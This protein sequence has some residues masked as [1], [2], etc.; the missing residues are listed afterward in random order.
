[1]RI[2]KAVLV[3]LAGAVLADAAPVLAQPAKVGVINLVRLEKESALA[4]RAAEQLRQEFEP[5][6]LQLEEQ[7]KRA[8]AAR[9]R[10][11]KERGT[12]SATELRNRERDV[13]D[14]LRKSEQARVRFVEELEARKNEHRAKFFEEANAS[15]K[16]VAEAGKFDLILQKAAFARPAVDVTPLVLKEM[17]KRG[18]SR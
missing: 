2:S 17:A 11:A 3:V 18:G 12:L 13:A 7:T 6:R 16:A 9:D 15:I 5:R 8:L 10:L 14:Q 4:A 1:M